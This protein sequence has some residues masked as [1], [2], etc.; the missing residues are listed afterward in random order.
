MADNTTLN[1]G[2]GGDV[3]ASDD[4]SGVK[5]QRNKIVIGAD[6]V[7]DGD[8]SATNPL[9]IINKAVSRSV[10]TAYEAGR[11][12][13]AAAATFLGVSG[14]NSK[15]SG[16]FIQI[17]NTTTAPADTAVP[18]ELLYVPASSSFVFEAAAL[19]GD[20]YSTGI[21]ICNSS[22]GPTKT[23]GSADCW[24]NVRYR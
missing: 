14:Y 12:V 1:T 17:H 24:F 23:I 6:G 3:I 2:T 22:T 16:Q 15:T 5:F 20:A 4:I 13:S 8:V 11:V 21:Y 9:P 10:S 18:I 19:A 7:N